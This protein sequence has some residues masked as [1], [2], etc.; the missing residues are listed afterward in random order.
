[1]TFENCYHDTLRSRLNC[2]RS[3]G[4]DT[5]QP[6]KQNNDPSTS[7]SEI[8]NVWGVNEYPPLAN[9]THKNGMYDEF[10]EILIFR[11]SGCLN[12]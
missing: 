8:I 4:L 7:Y 12:K 5:N 6:K 9:Y 11:L 2:H 3:F 10:R 1:M